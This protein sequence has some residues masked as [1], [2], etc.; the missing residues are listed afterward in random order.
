MPLTSPRSTKVNAD[1]SSAPSGV[2]EFGA[3]AGGGEVGD[4][5]AEQMAASET[6][7][8]DGA[9]GRLFVAVVDHGDYGLVAGM[10][11]GE[12]VLVGHV[13]EGGE[14]VALARIRAGGNVCHRA[15]FDARFLTV[16]EQ[17]AF[18]VAESARRIVEGARVGEVGRAEPAEGD[19]VAV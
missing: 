17:P 4:L 10:G 11:V 18:V 16:E 7:L 9:A 15:A 19:A 6:G 13:A 8:V 12:Q 3:L 2:V 14:L 5:D 1:C